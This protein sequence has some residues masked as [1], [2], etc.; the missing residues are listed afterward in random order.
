[1]CTLKWMTYILICYRSAFLLADCELAFA[2]IVRDND[3]SKEKL[4][5]FTLDRDSFSEQPPK[6]EVLNC[7]CKNLAIVLCRP[8]IVSSYFIIFIWPQFQLHYITLQL[9][10]VLFCV[11][12]SPDCPVAGYKVMQVHESELFL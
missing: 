4:Y 12:Y 1:M 3:M 9:V 8:D 5:S 2:F 11:F 10:L 7:I 6:T